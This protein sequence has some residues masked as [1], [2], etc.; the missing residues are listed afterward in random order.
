ME[1]FDYQEDL[2]QKMQQSSIQENIHGA[3]VTIKP[4]PDEDEDGVLDP[5]FYKMIGSLAA[6]TK[7][8]PD[9][10]LKLGPQKQTLEVLRMVFNL[11]KSKSITNEDLRVDQITIRGNDNN[12]IPLRIYH[13]LVKQEKTPILYYIHGGGFF[14]GSLDVCDEFLRYIASE[15][16][17]LVFSIDYRLAPT[18]PY[19]KGHEDCYAGLKW[20]SQNAMHYQGDVDSLF[21]AGDSAGGNLAHYCVVKD[22]EEK[23]HQIKG[24]CLI[25]P[26]LNLAEVQDEL[27]SWNLDQFEMNEKQK[28]A[29]L[30]SIQMIKN[31]GVD[32]MNGV[33][34]TDVNNIYLTPYLFE[35]SELP[36]TLITV[37]EFDFLR[38]EALA[39]AAKLQQNKCIV[40]TH[41]YKGMGH[42]FIDQIGNFPQSEDAAIE[43][44]KFILK[45]STK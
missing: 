17:I 11:K 30:L 13:P 28:D 6:L 31:G 20:V 25:Y 40:E 15:F 35:S 45:Y 26:V 3:T 42:G 24:Q 14:A 37:G 38:V 8:V 44:A 32:I 36:P 22:I 34:Q 21:I 2:L 43:I 33:L 10:Y 18:D 41:L 7:W 16:N 12:L 29:T 9:K 1:K 23:A 4:I 39:Y 5:R 19:P 27:V